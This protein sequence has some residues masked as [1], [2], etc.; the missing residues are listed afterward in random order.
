[1]FSLDYFLVNNTSRLLSAKE[2][3]RIHVQM[4]D[5]SSADQYSAADDETIRKKTNV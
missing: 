3:M 5:V 1:L 4:L 2:A